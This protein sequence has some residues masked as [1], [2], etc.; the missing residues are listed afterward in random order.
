MWRRRSQRSACRAVRATAMP[1]RGRRMGAS[2]H[3]FGIAATVTKAVAAYTNAQKFATRQ[4]ADSNAFHKAM[5]WQDGFLT[6]G[7]TKAMLKT[8]RFGDGAWSAVTR[9]N[10]TFGGKF[11]RLRDIER[12]DVDGDGKDDLVIA[13]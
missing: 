5:P 8:W 10:P 4:A 7:A 11:D 13:T 2:R 6:I 1:T 9:W 12:G 3:G